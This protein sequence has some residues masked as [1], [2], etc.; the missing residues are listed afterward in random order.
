MRIKPSVLT[1][2][3]LY[4]FTLTV[5]TVNYT[6]IAKISLIGNS[7]PYKGYID[8]YPSEGNALETEFELT[9]YGFVD[10]EEDLPLSYKFVYSINDP[11]FLPSNEKILSGFKESNTFRGARFSSVLMPVFILNA[12]ILTYLLCM[13]CYRGIFI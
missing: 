9:A 2:G 3:L 13:Y 4:Q 7:P 5:N 6:S 12:L 1:P 10:S 11:L 8:Y